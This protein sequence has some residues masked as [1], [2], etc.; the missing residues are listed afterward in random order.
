MKKYICENCRKEVNDSQSYCHECGSQFK[1]INDAQDNNII[2]FTIEYKSVSMECQW[3]F[4]DEN[5]EYGELRFENPNSGQWEK[6]IEQAMQGWS[7]QDE[8]LN[9]QWEKLVELGREFINSDVIRDVEDGE[10]YDLEHYV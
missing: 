2:E 5:D 6:H 7:E 3:V 4:N 10:T 1:K 8:E 9:K